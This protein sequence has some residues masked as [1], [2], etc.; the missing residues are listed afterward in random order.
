MIAV[1]EDDRWYFSVWYTVAELARRESD[2]PPSRPGPAGERQPQDHLPGRVR[3][4]AP[5]T[6]RG[7]AERFCPGDF[8]EGAPERFDQSSPKGSDAPQLDV[9]QPALGLATV[10][11]DGRW[12]VS[13]TRTVLDNVVA[14]LKVLDRDDLRALR[15]LFEQ[16]E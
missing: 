10:R 3:Q 9:A 11:S 1:P 8:G 12:Y 13:P 15:D 5:L 2:A 7:R 16:F 4:P 6:G 14:T